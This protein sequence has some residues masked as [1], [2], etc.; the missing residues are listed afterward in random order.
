MAEEEG[1]AEQAEG[2]ASPARASAGTRA[3]NQQGGSEDG[4]AGEGAARA[5]AT[6]GPADDS[7]SAH[8]KALAAREAGEPTGEAVEAG[9]EMVGV[10]SSACTAAPGHGVVEPEADGA[11]GTC[12]AMN[13]AAGHGEATERSANR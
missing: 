6:Y 12:R 7:E 10:A 13:P 3:A 1:A 5:G 2:P 11:A 9:Y 8:E 4:A